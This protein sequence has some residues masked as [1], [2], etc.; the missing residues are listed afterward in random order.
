ME[1]KGERMAFS[2]RHGSSAELETP[3][4]QDQ[5]LLFLDLIKDLELEDWKRSEQPVPRTHGTAH[6]E[7]DIDLP[8]S[9]LDP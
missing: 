1:V 5:S 7:A 3:H 4:L 9:R 8:M 6:R 2:S